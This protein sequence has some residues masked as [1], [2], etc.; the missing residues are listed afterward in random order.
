M[1]EATASVNGK[2]LSHAKVEETLTGDPLTLGYKPTLPLDTLWGPDG[3]PLFQ[4]R[5][6][7]EYMM[8]HPQVTASL[9][10]YKSGIAGAEFWGGPNPLDSDD[11]KGV[12]VCES[13]EVSAWIIQQCAH[14]WDIGV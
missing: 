4:I 2:H 14:F 9:N 12:P 5:R 3:L 7:I 1:S 6:D 8:T 13:K 10:Y 11:E